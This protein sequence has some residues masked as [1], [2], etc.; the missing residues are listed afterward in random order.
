MKETL[1]RW[2]VELGLST[3]I[4]HSIEPLAILV[5]LF[6][7]TLFTA[8]IAQKFLAPLIAAAV[9]KSS[10]QWDD[11]LAG[12]GFFTQLVRL[13]PI[14]TLYVLI[15][16]TFAPESRLAEFIR[17]LALVL[18]VTTGLAILKAAFKTVLGLYNTTELSKE[19]PIRGYIDAAIIILYIIAGVLIISVVTGKSP[20]GILS[21]LGGLTVVLLLVFKD[22]I[23]GFVASLE[24]HAYDMVRIGD[25]IEMPKFGADGDV[26]DI[27]IHTVKVQ[28]WD[29]TITS[30]PT[31]A[32][33]SDSFKNWRGMAESGGRRI[34][35]SIFIDMNSITFCTD[36][37]LDRFSRYELI[38]EY[39]EE[40]K[41]EIE[42]YNQGKD[43][44]TAVLVNG[45]RQTNVGVFRAYIK[46]YLRSHPEI[47]QNM[48]FLVRHLSPTS[49]G[50]PIEIY[51]FSRDTVWA[52]YEGIQADI[53]DHILAVVPEFE[54][55][56]FQYPSGVDLGRTLGV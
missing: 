7:L 50:L 10:I 28:N 32:M 49:Q 15:D 24:I 47:H 6:I 40:K 25:W 29:K 54:L 37:M 34:K 44:D 19:K 31:Y 13:L 11:I 56:T 35:R 45:R 43:T 9:H 26:V 55:R 53:F 48:T 39:L 46:A 8:W 51:I 36:E 33:V 21:L 52:N 42:A 18:F 41:S 27:S 16:L 22:T 12:H 1:H 3:N 2:L 5:S 17:R 38:K 20:W 4:A 30:I 14:A 23:L